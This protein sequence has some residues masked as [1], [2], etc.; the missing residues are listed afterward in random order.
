M[1]TIWFMYKFNN[2][3]TRSLYLCDGK[4]KKFKTTDKAFDF[5]ILSGWL[6][7]YTDI[8]YLICDMEMRIKWRSDS[9][10]QQI[11]LF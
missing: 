4:I 10:M 9:K 6:D 2:V 8:I 1:R 5:L 7:V 11:K 3:W